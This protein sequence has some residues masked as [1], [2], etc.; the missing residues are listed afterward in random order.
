MTHA[1]SHGAGGGRAGH[2]GQ[3]FRLSPD[4]LLSCKSETESARAAARGRGLGSLSPSPRPT[5]PQPPRHLGRPHLS[6]QQEVPFLRLPRPPRSAWARS[7]HQHQKTHRGFNAWKKRL[8]FP[9][10]LPLDYPPTSETS[11]PSFQKRR[12]PESQPRIRT[13]CTRWGQRP[14]L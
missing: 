1:L 4:P 5:R 14:G 13:Q 2:R 3:V 7:L 9:D 6:G 10:R 8:L 12:P 11:L